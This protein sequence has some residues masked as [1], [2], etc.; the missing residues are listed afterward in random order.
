MDIQ[1][2]AEPTFLG[3]PPEIFEHIAEHASNAD[4][5]ALRL[6]SRA[7]ASRVLRTYTKAHFTCRNIYLCLEDDLLQAI[8]I[9]DHPTFGPALKQLNVNLDR[10]GGQSFIGK[11]K[12]FLKDE[13]ELQARLKLYREGQE[14]FKESA[15]DVE[16]L[17]V[18]FSK[19]R[20]NAL[21]PQI[22]ISRRRSILEQRLDPQGIIKRGGLIVSPSWED[23]RPFSANGSPRA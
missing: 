15:K 10:I 20:G 11:T 4:L 18:L 17:K 22:T 9:A 6:T 16:L 5:R 8:E 14:S 7:T 1:G 12:L 13:V 23:R 2:K 3:V 21:H 19:L